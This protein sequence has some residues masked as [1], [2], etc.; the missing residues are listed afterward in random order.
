MKT[1]KHIVATIFI[2]SCF[3]FAV[4]GAAYIHALL[5]YKSTDGIAIFASLMVFAI[6]YTATRLVDFVAFVWEKARDD[7]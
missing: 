4:I 5:V 6:I 7:G 1:F 2:L 3:A